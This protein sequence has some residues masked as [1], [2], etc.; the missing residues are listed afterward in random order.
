VLIVNKLFILL[1]VS[2]NKEP[3]CRFEEIPLHRMILEVYAVKK[4]SFI[5]IFISAIL[6]MVVLTPC[7]NAQNLEET[8]PDNFLYGSALLSN[9]IHGPVNFAFSDN[10]TMTDNVT[11]TKAEILKEKGV[12]GKGIDN[13]PGLQKFFNNFSKAI[14]RL[15]NRF[16]FRNQEYNGAGISD[17]ITATDNVTMT[18]SEILKNSGVPGKGIDNAPGLQKPFNP[19]TN[20]AN[21]VMNNNQER[22][23]EQHKVNFSQS[24]NVTMNKAGFLQ[25]NGVQGGGIENAPGLKKN[26][27]G[28]PNTSN[29]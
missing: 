22:V 3:V 9:E 5:S 29:H 13:A 14:E 7:V 25:Q 16:K 26:S 17:N 24:D 19:N 12:P 21:G 27:K 18:K 2:F 23:K 15:R 11:M 6:C 10:I 1:Y 8:E 4:M 20:G 28:G